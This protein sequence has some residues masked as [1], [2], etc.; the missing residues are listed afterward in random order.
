ME[1]GYIE[2]NFKRILDKDLNITPN[3]FSFESKIRQGT[4]YDLYNNKTQRIH[5]DTL[6]KIISTLNRLAEE[7]NIRIRYNVCDLLNYVE[8]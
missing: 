1:N 3:N 4:I 7:K 8:K 6:I 5:I 2:I